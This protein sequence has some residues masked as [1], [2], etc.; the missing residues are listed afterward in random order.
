MYILYIHLASLVAPLQAAEICLI[1]R[2]WAFG[3]GSLKRQNLRHVMVELEGCI[4]G[5]VQDK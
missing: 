4:Q 1:K 2:K 3:E 5:T